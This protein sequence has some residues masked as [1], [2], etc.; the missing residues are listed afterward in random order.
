MG[1]TDNE[2]YTIYVF[3]PSVLSCICSILL[4]FNVLRG[5]YKNYFFHQ[6]SAV[7]AF[8]DIFQCLGIFLDSPWTDDA[9]YPAAYFFLIGS[10][11]KVLTI[12]Y[13]T[14]IVTHV[15]IYV[16]SPSKKR[17]LIYCSIGVV[18]VLLSTMMLTVSEVARKYI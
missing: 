12:M 2:W 6:M 10:L 5:A 14:A 13:I 7:L 18:C 3:S 11:C 4:V 9:C 15:I 8:F 1:L 17:K 16:E